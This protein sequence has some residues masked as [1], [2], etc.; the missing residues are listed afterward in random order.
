MI[1][2][3]RKL[4]ALCCTV[5]LMALVAT[6]VFSASSG[7]VAA[8]VTTQTVVLTLGSAV[9]ASYGTPAYGTQNNVPTGSP[10]PTFAA[11]NGGTATIDVLI[12]G[13]DAVGATNIGTPAVPE[14]ATWSLGASPGYDTYVHKWLDG[15]TLNTM[16]SSPQVLASGVGPAGSKTFKL[17]MSMPTG[18]SYDDTYSFSVLLTAVPHI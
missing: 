3:K 6:P 15:V 16:T 17:R 1:L 10:E 2:Q 5:A 14:Y 18:S 12:G 9:T 13:T 7:E 8:T 11:T 4:I